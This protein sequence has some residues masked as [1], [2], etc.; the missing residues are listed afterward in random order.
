MI[1]QYILTSREAISVQFEVGDGIYFT[2]FTTFGETLP[3]VKSLIIAIV[4]RLSYFT[5]LGM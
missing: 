3:S 4:G 5:S 1:I 2:F